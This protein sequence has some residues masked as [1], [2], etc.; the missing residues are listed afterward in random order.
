MIGGLT[1]WGFHPDAKMELN[2]KTKTY[3]TTLL[4]KQ[5]WY[6]YQFGYLT[7]EG[8]YMSPIEGDH[9]ET[10]NEYEVFVYFRDVGS[11]YDEL[12]GYVN[13]NPN[14]RRL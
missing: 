1:N 2:S 14:K 9:F 8:W 10:E 6:D 11:R 3:Q 4:L 13:L 12:V 7:E 5:G